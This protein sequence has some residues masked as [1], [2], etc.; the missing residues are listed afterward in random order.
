M[1]KWVVDAEHFAGYAKAWLNPSGVCPYTGKTADDYKREGFSVFDDRQYDR[2]VTDW[3]N[4]L[5]GVWAEESA[6][7][8]SDALNVLPPVGCF[9]GGFFVSERYA[10]NISAYHQEAGGHYYTSLQRWSTPRSAILD[11]LAKWI[12]S[13][14]MC[15]ACALCRTGC[16][17]SSESVFTGCVRR[18]EVQA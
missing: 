6:E 10:S 1:S 15:K 17:E 5:C 8:Y 16:A 12:H 3:E 18:A 14:P 4:S 7:D 13:A 11:D 2:L 9:D